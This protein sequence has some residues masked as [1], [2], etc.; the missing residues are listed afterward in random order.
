MPER[1]P[2][3]IADAAPD[4]WGRRVIEY[5][6]N[7]ARLSEIDY[8]LC[9]GGERIG[10]LHFQ[11]DPRRYQPPKQ[12]TATLSQLAE[13]AAYV[14]TQAPLPADLR[15]APEHGTSIGGGT[16]EGYHS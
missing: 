9:G 10:A 7:Q 3:A 4:N 11:P 14:E 15:L 2:G 8:L 5:R 1:L 16:T 13:A 12:L 6:A